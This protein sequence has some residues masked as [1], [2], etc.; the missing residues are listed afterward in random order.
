M[1]IQI[2]N[3]ALWA[4]II[5]E[6]L[7]A[8]DTNRALTSFEKVR[9][10]NALAKAA[11][12]IE[13]DANFIHWDASTQSILI[14]SN[15]TFVYEIGSDLVCQCKAALNGSVCWHRAA[16]RLISRYLLADRVLAASCSEAAL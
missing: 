3:K 4:E 15:F 11:A 12:R 10:T 14:L 1:A 16:R 2:K 7:I 13:D 9:Y 8:I 5:S 6:E